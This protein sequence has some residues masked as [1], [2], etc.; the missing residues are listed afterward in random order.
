MKT[1]KHAAHAAQ[2][3]ARQTIPAMTDK[4]LSLDEKR[5]ANELKLCIFLVEHNLPFHISDHLTKLIESL[6][7]SSEDC[8]KK[9]PVREPKPQL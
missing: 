1:K 3:K 5:K 6:D 2:A 7:I 9:C 8:M 4:G